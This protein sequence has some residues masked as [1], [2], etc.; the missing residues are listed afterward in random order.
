MKWW[1]TKGTRICVTKR[2]GTTIRFHEVPYWI[3]SSFS[4]AHLTIWK[5]SHFMSI[6][7]LKGIQISVM[8]LEIGSGPKQAWLKLDNFS[9]NVGW[10]HRRLCQRYFISLFSCTWH[11]DIF[12]LDALA[13]L[14]IN[15]TFQT[16]FLFILTVQL[17]LHSDLR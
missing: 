12:L 3:Y 17:L 16:F 15:K 14:I 7:D 6:F 4:F 11:W 1:I 2:D 13:D 9:Q 5:K 10:Q 8:I